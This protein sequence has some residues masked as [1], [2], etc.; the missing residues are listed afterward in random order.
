MASALTL[1]ESH[2]VRG[3]Q[4]LIIVPVHFELPVAIL[5][6]GLVRP[7]AQ[8]LHAVHE[9]RDEF[10]LPH[11]GALLIAR[12]ELDVGAVT[13]RHALRNHE[14]RVRAVDFR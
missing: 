14:C 1:G 5:V 7:P 12:L 11:Q 4:A 8:L 2:P 10:E 13:D 9:G 6:I 3:E